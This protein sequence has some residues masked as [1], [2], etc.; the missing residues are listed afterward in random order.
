MG[1]P[2]GNQFWKVRSK[3]GRSRLFKSPKILWDACCDYFD[4]VEKNPLYESKAFTFQGSSWIEKVPKMRAMTQSG[5]CIFLEITQE[6]WI[7]WRKEKDYSEVV[8][9]VDEI[10]KTQKFTGAAADL[11]NPN[12]IARDLGLRDTATIDHSSTDG[13]MTPVTR[14]EIVPL[15]S[16]DK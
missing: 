2:K 13:T 11:L 9:K 16:E 3:H 10:I 6:T 5:L 8:T 12:I 14:I 1:A 15:V 7:T 4:W